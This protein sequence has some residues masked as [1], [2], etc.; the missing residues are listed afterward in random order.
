MSKFTSDFIHS[1][2][3]FDIYVEHKYSHSYKDIIAHE[4]HFLEK[5]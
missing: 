2:I 5:Y 1:H 4:K 3:N